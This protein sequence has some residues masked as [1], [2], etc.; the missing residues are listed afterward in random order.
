M[1]N[2]AQFNRIK[3][4]TPRT[5]AEIIVQYFNAVINLVQVSKEKVNLIHVLSS[6]L[7]LNRMNVS[8]A[9]LSSGTCKINLNPRKYR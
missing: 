1:F 4:N 2:S 6:V 5:I 3:F 7:Q 8:N 9:N